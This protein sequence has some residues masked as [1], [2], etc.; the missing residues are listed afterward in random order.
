MSTHE[1]GYISPTVGIE[2]LLLFPSA[3]SGDPVNFFLTIFA[4]IPGTE[5]T[6]FL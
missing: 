2:W 6:V 5:T 1:G 4:N 3:K